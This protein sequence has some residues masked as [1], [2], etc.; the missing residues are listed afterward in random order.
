MEILEFKLQFIYVGFKY[1]I[2][3]DEELPTAEAEADCSKNIIRARQSVDADLRNSVGRARMTIAHEIGHLAHSHL[4]VQQRSVTA[5]AKAEEFQAKHFAACFLMPMHIV[6]TFKSVAKIAATFQVS[7]EAAKIRHKEVVRRRRVK[8]KL[9]QEWLENELQ[10]YKRLENAVVPLVEQA[11]IGVGISH[12]KIEHRIKPPD[13]ALEKIKRKKY[14]D[15]AS[16]LTDLLGIRLVLISKAAVEQVREAIKA[17]FAVDYAN[18]CDKTSD[19]RVDQVGYRSVHLVCALGTLRDTLPEYRHL[20]D[21]KFEI[22]I[23]TIL[24]H[25]WADASHNTAYK[26]EAEVPTELVR[27]LNLWAAQLELFDADIKELEERLKRRKP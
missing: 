9:L 20:T 11:L 13:K 10:K 16:Q 24:E 3:P 2:V 25:I 1:I 19:R 21:L 14:T 6:E 15:P 23:R 27:R 12:F 7:T 8:R 17:L 5:V 18:S 4:G 26:F 22:Q